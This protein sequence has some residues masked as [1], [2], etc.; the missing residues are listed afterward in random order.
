MKKMALLLFLWM[1]STGFSQ[2]VLYSE[3]FESPTNSF[4]LNT[5]D[6]SGTVGGDNVWL[7]NNTYVGGSGSIVCFGFPI[8]FTINN[9]PNQPAGITNGPNSSY[10]HTASQAAV[11]SGITCAS[12]VPSDGSC[13]VNSS[14]FTK[15]SSDINTVGETNINLNFR[16]LCGGSAQAFGEIYYSING[17]ASWVLQ[18][19]N[20]FNTATWATSNLTNAVWSNQNTL[21]FGFRFL[22]NTASTG[23]EPGFSIDEIVVTSACSPSSATISP[24]FCGIYTSPSGNYT[25][26]NS[27]TYADTIPNVSGCDSVLTINLTITSLNNTVSVNELNL[28]SNQTGGTYQWVTCPAMTP[29]TGATNQSYSVTANGSYAVIASIPGCSDT[30]ACIVINTVGLSE[31]EIGEGITLYPNP[32][33][34]QFTV[35][36]DKMYAQTSIEIVDVLGKQILTGE[37]TNSDQLKLK[38]EEPA[39]IYFIRITAD[40][41]TTQRRL[42]IE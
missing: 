3:N 35:L 13:V 16:W 14:I 9:T 5:T 18:Q 25:W 11:T 4:T 30:S 20:M 41:L 19:S 33:N 29:I 26:A 7:K 32:T 1:S 15:M 21:R 28:S 42:V 17:G 38:L 31:K 27:G 34:G 40:E 10:M 36:L 24:S 39:G 23:S 6:M 12:Y 37:F 2:T 22:N 8:S